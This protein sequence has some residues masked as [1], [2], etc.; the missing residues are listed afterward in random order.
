MKKT[1]KIIIA[2]GAAAV[3]VIGAV[4]VYANV[5]NKPAPIEERYTFATAARGEVAQSVTV[6]GNVEADG[7]TSLY[8]EMPQRA[9]KVHVKAGDEVRAGQLL[10]EFDN[11]AELDELNRRLGEAELNLSNA[12]LN[13]ELI[14]A[15][16]TGNELLQYISD[17]AA[18]DKNL[19]DAQNDVKSVEI[20][21]TQQQLRLDDAKATLDRTK[22]LYGENIATEQNLEQAQLNYD[23]AV[24]AMEELEAQLAA[25]QGTIELRQR[26][27]RL[28]EEKLSN[29][30]NKQ[31]D[32]TTR[33]KSELQA[34]VV[35]LS[36]LEIES[37]QAEIAKYCEAVYSP[38]SGYISEINAVEGAVASKSAAV[39]KICDTSALI[40]KSDVSEFDAPALELGQEARISTSGLPDSYFA[41]V[42]TKIAAG[43]VKKENSADDEVI[44]RV[45]LTVANPGEKLKPG[46]SVDIEIFVER[47]ENAVYLPAQAIGTDSESGGKYVY[48]IDGGKLAKKA[49]STGLYGNKYV[50][51]TSGVSEGD[52][53]VLNPAGVTGMN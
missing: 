31:G 21:I 27:Q 52:K 50:E 16:V 37:I 3:T 51:I 42:V 7:T 38:I 4:Y 19:A 53:A 9:S 43:A 47:R 25:R 5:I 14:G 11:S 30:R 26:Q 34:N 18:A 49:V 32:D 28:A 10:V 36:E 8:I 35:R 44:V 1:A 17:I 40:V 23:N 39:I 2:L 33:I 6:T 20:K 22:T 29:A 13:L 45:E 12:K 48:V 15:P 41:G 24:A 46:Y